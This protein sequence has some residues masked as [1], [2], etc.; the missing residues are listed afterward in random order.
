M[1]SDEQIDRSVNTLQ[2]T[3]S[4]NASQTND[5][6]KWAQSRRSDLRAIREQRHEK[7]EQLMTLLNKPSPDP[8]TVGRATI[9]LK[10]I[11]DQ[12]RAKQA[13]LESRFSNL[14]NPAQ[15]QIVN[16]LRKQAET[17]QA[18]RRIG[19]LHT[20]NTG[21]RMTRNSQGGGGEYSGF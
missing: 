11:Q 17:F 2:R 9:E 18:L 3:L 13:D 1:A 21:M 6:R 20:P 12:V 4:L 8:A 5:I 15:R 7:F 19:A 16:D 14:L 10:A